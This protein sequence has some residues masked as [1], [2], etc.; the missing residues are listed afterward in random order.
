MNVWYSCQSCPPQTSSKSFDVVSSLYINQKEILRSNHPPSF[1]SVLLILR[2]GMLNLSSSQCIG[3]VTTFL[4]QEAHTANRGPTHVFQLTRRG[5]HCGW[6]S[7]TIDDDF[8]AC[9]VCSKNGHY[10]DMAS[11]A[12]H[13]TEYSDLRKTSH[14]P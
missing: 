7:K 12:S 1:V 11:F 6:C 4:D 5:R 10:F 2:G 8:F 14:T 3:C 13:T 9:E